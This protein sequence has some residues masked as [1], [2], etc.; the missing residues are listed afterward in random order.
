MRS[1]LRPLGVVVALGWLAQPALAQEGL[2]GGGATGSETAPAAKAATAFIPGT[3]TS[4][5]ES[6]RDGQAAVIE[7]LT[8]G[9]PAV[10]A[11]VV[12]V[13]STGGGTLYAAQLKGERFT[14]DA[15]AEL[16]D[17]PAD[18]VNA[19]PVDLVTKWSSRSLPFRVVFKDLVV[20][21]LVTR[22]VRRAAGGS[23]KDG[24]IVA[25]TEVEAKSFTANR[26]IAVGDTL[27]ITAPAEL[28]GEYKVNGVGP[29]GSI[30]PAQ[31]FAVKDASDVTYEVRRVGEFAT[32]F[33]QDPYFT[34][35]S[36]E[37][38]L[39]V[40]Y[41]WPDPAIDTSPLF[42]EKR[43][44]VGKNPNNLDLT[45]TLYNFSDKPIV[46]LPGLKVT[47]W[48][49]PEAGGGSMFRPPTNMLGASC[50]TNEALEHNTFPQLHEKAIENLQN[51]QGNAATL[52]FTTPTDFIAIDTNYFI[53]LVLPNPRSQ[54]V[55][56]QCQQGAIVFDANK[57]GAWAI[58]S[59]YYVSANQTLK[60][61]A[62][63]CVPE[64]WLK[65]DGS[66]RG[67]AASYSALGLAN[68][69]AAKDVESSWSVLRNQSGADVPA[70][71]KAREEIMK[72]RDGSLR[73][74][75]ALFNGPK[76]RILLAETYP[77]MGEAVNLG[78]FAFIAKPLH[79]LLVWFHDGVGSWAL[80]IILLTV[81]VKLVLL[82]LTNKSYRSMQK[83]QQLKPKLDELKKK[84]GADRQKFASEQ[85][86]LFKREGANPLS[87]C[88]PMLLQMPVWFGLY[89]SI[90]SSV[91]LYHAPMG[92]WIHDLSAPDPYFVMPI[93]LGVLMF[94]QTLLTASTATM[95]GMQ[96]KIMKYG[97]PIMFSVFMLFLPSG[98]VLYIFVNVALT[99]VQNLVIKRRMNKT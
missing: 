40:T 17:V 92:L 70:L 53:S 57:P 73:Y 38:G 96:A 5:T 79:S 25:P 97:M 83:M 29:G 35:V 16:A 37:P 84:Y 68:G 50:R 95:D 61:G 85:M 87:G 6:L 30:E 18:K 21:D 71:D 98:L 45:V 48:Q 3:V 28:A 27:V 32:L 72:A 1:L 66:A 55:T 93:L 26:P 86:A 14:R 15:H 11:E 10:N 65:R 19:G 46:A 74:E 52:S 76:D 20:T 94:V 9:V 63:G 69:A 33:D 39:P 62:G 44:S 60:P 88:F 49:H 34:R 43:F 77:V 58:Y 81:V 41:V 59:A 31:P 4:A 8:V 22:V 13:L 24:R 67:C 99:I 80:A 7:R 78:M 90:Q 56:G 64:W 91:E 36:V 23:I 47:G 12:Y 54:A 89:Q 42:I 82:P 75:Y 2:G 51:G